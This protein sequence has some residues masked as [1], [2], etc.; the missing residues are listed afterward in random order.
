MSRTLLDLATVI[1]QHTGH[2]RTVLDYT[3]EMKRIVDRAKEPGFD[4]TG[5]E[6]LTRYVATDTFT[7]VGPFKDA[8][9]WPDYVTFLTGWAPF[10]HWECSFRRITEARNLVFLE[11]EERVDPND[12]AAAAN[13]LSVFE[14]DDSD[15]INHLDVH[16]Q[17]APALRPA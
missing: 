14:F 10:Q 7:R 11:L 17:M 3:A 15:R 13:S 12:P 2:A 1:D 6:S 4:A 5:C 9:E 16:L 8:M